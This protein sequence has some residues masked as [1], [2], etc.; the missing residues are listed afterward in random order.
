MGLQ[1]SVNYHKL[2]KN[3]Q[4]E[5]ELVHCLLITLCTIGELTFFSP[6]FDHI[7]FG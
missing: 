6:Y 7:V 2:A 4:S 5:K 3:N 1:D